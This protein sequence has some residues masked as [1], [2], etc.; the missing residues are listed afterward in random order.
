MTYNP[1]SLNGKTILV[2]GASS[3]IG[4]ATAIECSKLGATVIVTGRNAQR[5]QE[6]FEQLEQKNPPLS[7][8]SYAPNPK[9]LN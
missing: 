9:S 6:T 7:S 2:T 3:G 1:F 4:Q 8:S 5:L